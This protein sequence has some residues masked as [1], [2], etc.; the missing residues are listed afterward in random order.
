MPI[1]VPLIQA[2]APTLLL[3]LAAKGAGAKLPAFDC[4][5]DATVKAAIKSNVAHLR[6][7]TVIS[8]TVGSRFIANRRLKNAII[9][10]NS[11]V[12]PW[13]AEMQEIANAGSPPS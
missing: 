12:E 2:I 9:W 5:I 10:G 4:S 3:V 1:I 6:Y 11:S 7:S 8:L 13:P